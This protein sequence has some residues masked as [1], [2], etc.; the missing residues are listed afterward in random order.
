MMGVV[1]VEAGLTDPTLL[2]HPCTP[3]VG[4]GIPLDPMGVAPLVVGVGGMP[5][6]GVVVGMGMEG[7]TEETTEVVVPGVGMEGTTEEEEGVAATE[8]AGEGDITTD[9]DPRPQKSWCDCPELLPCSQCTHMYMHTCYD[10]NLTMHTHT[11]PAAHNA[12][13]YTCSQCTWY[14]CYC[15]SVR[16]I[17]IFSLCVF[18]VASMGRDVCVANQV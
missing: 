5:L 16:R 11:I 14:A 10:D 1:M 9:T 7:T 17:S 18:C 2:P 15:F 13:M 12:C 6:L 4:V 3:H 8:G